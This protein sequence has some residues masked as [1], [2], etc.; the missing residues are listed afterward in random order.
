MDNFYSFFHGF[1]YTG[2]IMAWNMVRN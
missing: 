2:P 1:W